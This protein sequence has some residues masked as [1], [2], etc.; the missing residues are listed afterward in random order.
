MRNNIPSND[1]LRMACRLQMDHGKRRSTTDNDL[2]YIL[3]CFLLID[4]AFNRTN[5]ASS[6]RNQNRYFI[7][8]DIMAASSGTALRH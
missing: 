4:R 5:H 7:Y 6:I 8:H 3:I 1:L 2:I